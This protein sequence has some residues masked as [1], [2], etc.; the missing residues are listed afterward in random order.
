MSTATFTDVERIRRLPWLIVGDVFNMVFVLLTFSGSVFMLF[1]DELGLDNAQIGFMLSLIPFVG[2]MAPF[3]APLAGRIGYKRMFITFWFWRKFVMAFLLLTPL[4]IA[5]FGADK[6]FYWVAVII[7]GFSILR[8][9]AENGSYPWRKEVI[10]DSIRGK[11]T[12]VSSMSTTVAS[13]IVMLVAGYVIDNGNGLNRFMLLLAVGIG[14]GFL[15]VLSYSRMPGEPATCR[16]DYGADH[17]RGMWSALHR[18]E[19]VYF[20]ATLGLVTV[21]NSLTLSFVPLFAKKE[22][23]L[24]EGNVVWLSI[25]TYTGALISSYLWGWMA[26]RYGSQPLMQF[27]IAILFMLPVT[28]FLMP[29]HSHLSMTLALTISSLTGIATLAWQISWARYFFV[30]TIPAEANRS[31]YIALYYAWFGFVS[32]LGPLLA[33]QILALAANVRASFFMFNIDSY[34]TLYGSSLVLLIAGMIAVSRLRSQDAPTFR[35]FTGLFLRGNPIRALESLVQYNFS[36]DEVSRVITTERM[37]DAKS[38][39]STNE[40]IEALN[41]PS[42]NVRYEAIHSIGR[43]PQE[44]ELV[45]ALLSKLTEG[46]SELSFEIIRSLGRQGDKRAIEPLRQ[47]LC[48]EFQLLEA[49]SARAL[50]MLGDTDS[51]SYFLHKLRTERNEILRLAYVSALGTLRCGEA[52]GELFTLLRHTEADVLRG[53]IGLALARIA[54]DERYYM[55]QWRTLRANPV[56]ATAQAILSLKKLAKH[57][58]GQALTDQVDECSRAFAQND[59]S[60]GAALLQDLLTQFPLDRLEPTQ[61]RILAECA[62]GLAEFGNDRIEFILLSLH[63]LDLALRTK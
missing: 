51:V 35:R 23:G 11:F 42:F 40:L 2:I 21:G 52:V 36:V 4:F 41:D 17:F 63:T 37:G 10:P 34:T 32:G 20:L 15:G 61:I 57:P 38:P 45:D 47:V 7:C 48:S 31:A 25:G 6:T 22:V 58:G 28:W 14:A 43:M 39:L 26:D 62:S 30:N 46:P 59:T 18:R 60:R 54:G 1:L 50:A 12:A 27:S 29:R 8:A 13:I 9:L 24:S 44:P 33:G 19:F 3:T 55:Q 53:E 5:H 56:L 49:S 16:Q